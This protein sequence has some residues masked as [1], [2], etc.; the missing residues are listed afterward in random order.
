MLFLLQDIHRV[1]AK[2]RNLPHNLSQNA[3]CEMHKR[4]GLPHFDGR[5]KQTNPRSHFEVDETYRP[6]L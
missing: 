2:C 6:F 4:I 5:I 1:G 3:T